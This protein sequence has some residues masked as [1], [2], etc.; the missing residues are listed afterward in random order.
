DRLVP[1]LEQGAQGGGSGLGIG[2][3]L[4]QGPGGLAAD[5][6]VL[7][8]QR[9]LDGG[10]RPLA[11]R[12]QRLDRCLAQV[13]RLVAEQLEQG[14]GGGGGRRADL[15]QGEGRGVSDVDVLVL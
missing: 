10:H 8:L 1:I 14:G 2:A 3:D 13:R 5:R 11:E 15:A 12:A 6:G 4:G 9:L 7:V